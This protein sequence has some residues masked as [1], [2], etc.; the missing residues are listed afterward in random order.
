MPIHTVLQQFVDT[1]H[2]AIADLEE[3]YEAGVPGE[4]AK[5]RTHATITAAMQRLHAVVRPELLHVKREAERSLFHALDSRE[6]LYK[7]MSDI[8]DLI[9]L[10]RPLSPPEAWYGPKMSFYTHLFRA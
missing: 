8:M 1:A 3:S 7:V 4:A 5:Q 10:Q 2:G 6:D 9:A